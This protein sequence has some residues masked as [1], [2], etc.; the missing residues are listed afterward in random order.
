[1][2]PRNVVTWM[3]EISYIRTPF[4]SQRVHVSQTLLKSVWQHFY[5]NFPLTTNKLSSKTS[6]SVRSKI[7]VLFVNRL[8]AD[9]MYFRHNFEN[10]AQ[11]VKTPLSQKRQTFSGI[12]IQFLEFTQNFPHFHKNGEVHRLNIWDVIESEKC[13]DLNDRRFLY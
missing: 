3:A 9:H 11:Y 2:S 6:L 7:S 12:F 1:M 10:F 4:Q 13:G 5:R 8:T